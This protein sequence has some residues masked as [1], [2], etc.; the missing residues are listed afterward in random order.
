MRVDGDE[1]VDREYMI[2]MGEKFYM[3]LYDKLGKKADLLD[4]L[5]EIMYTI[6][7]HTTISPISPTSKTF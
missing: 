2:Q 3:E 4:Y 6:P 5:H 1:Y 7:K